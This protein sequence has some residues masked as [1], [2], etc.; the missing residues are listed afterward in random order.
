MK[1][2]LNVLKMPKL[3]EDWEEQEEPTIQVD[4]ELIA[5]AKL[6]AQFYLKRYEEEKGKH[7]IENERR[8]N[9]IGLTGQKVF[10]V[11]LQ[12]LE[13]PNIHNDPIV[14]WRGKKD[15]DHRIPNI[16]T[17]ETKTFD[18]PYR[19]VL[20]KV[21]EWHGN[22]F[23]IVFKFTNE[24]RTE[25]KL[26]GYLT[27]TQVENLPISKKGEHYTPKADAYITDFNKLESAREFLKMIK[28]QASL[29]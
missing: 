28:T 24:E 6:H 18:Y 5:W 15:Y 20:I 27:K 29:Q 8:N 2:F 16:G 22:D 26:M 17:I 13:I 21:S 3:P 14:D 12:Q 19:K 7:W 4:A 11:I 10:D 23:C 25:L 1:P 9:R